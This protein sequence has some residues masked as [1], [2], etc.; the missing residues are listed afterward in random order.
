MPEVSRRTTEILGT[1]R[2]FA[3]VWALTGDWVAG[4]MS[5]RILDVWPEFW[6][7]AAKRSREGRRWGAG[8]T[9]GSTPWL[10][11]ICARGV[12]MRTREEEETEV[13]VLLT[14]KGRG[15]KG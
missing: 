13:E 8:R 7:S 9:E 3:G 2:K 4:V 11:E 5:L 14:V 12:W 10:R 15:G 6:A 1:S